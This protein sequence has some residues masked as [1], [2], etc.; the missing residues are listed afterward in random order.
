[1]SHSRYPMFDNEAYHKLYQ[2]ALNSGQFSGGFDEFIDWTYEQGYHHSGSDGLSGRL[3]DFLQSIGLNSGVLSSLISKWSG[4]GLT[5][6]QREEME[7]NEQQAAITRQR[8]DTQYQRTV[9]D[10]KAAG[11]NPALAMTNGA[12]VSPSS[13]QAQGNVN[14]GSNGMSM[15]DLIQLIR[16]PMEMRQMS[17]MTDADIAMKNAQTGLTVAETGKVQRESEGISNQ[18][19]WFVNTR[20]YERDFL[21]LRNEGQRIVNSLNSASIRKIEAEIPEI[22]ERIRLLSEQAT[23]EQYQR[24]LM[25]MQANLARVQAENIVALQPYQQALLNEQAGQA[26]AAA[27]FAWV[28]AAY[29]QRLI[30]DG[31]VEALCNEVI[32]RNAA[33]MSQD[34][35]N[36]AR[37]QADE[38]RNQLRHDATTAP[39]FNGWNFME[40]FAADFNRCVYGIADVLGSS[41]GGIVGAAAR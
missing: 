37:A 1:M 2:A 21:E 20:D 41:L 7:W 25:S 32:S 29:Q 19:E 3:Y 11:V 16:L 24:A 6:A 28:Q 34:Q 5:G 18:N 12:S 40:V 15:S 4:S 31:Y 36:R 13:A 14:S 33:N 39:E 22:Q 23:T 35:L 10:M 27:G 38:F 9:A 26:R 17:R 8:E 30:D